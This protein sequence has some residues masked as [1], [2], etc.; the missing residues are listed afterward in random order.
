[1]F[2][3]NPL[4]KN[5][6]GRKSCQDEIIAWIFILI[7]L[8][9]TVSI[10]LVTVLMNFNEMHG[11][12]AWYIG[13]IGF[14][15]FFVYKYKVF[16]QRADTIDTMK[17]VDKLNNPSPLKNAEREAISIILCK[18]RSNKERLNFFFIFIASF[19]ALLLAIYFDF[20]K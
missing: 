9:A 5:C 4:C 11:K 14:T 20:V 16:K 17:L 2:L 15:L 1:M 12:I 19:I 8:V 6:K 10:R 3:K 13:V 18:I 7:G